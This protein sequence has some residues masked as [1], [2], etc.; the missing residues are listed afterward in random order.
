V[1][2]DAPEKPGKADKKTKESTNNII[3][4]LLNVFS[5]FKIEKTIN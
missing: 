1:S 3:F 5:S 2:N 4:I